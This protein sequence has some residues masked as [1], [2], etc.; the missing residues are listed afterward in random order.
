METHSNIIKF[1]VENLGQEDWFLEIEAVDDLMLET[2]LPQWVKACNEDLD[3]TPTTPEKALAYILLTDKF[4]RRM[5]K[6]KL[7]SFQSD[8]LA[9]KVA[10]KTINTN[11]D[12]RIPEPQ[13]KFFYFP[14]MHSECLSDQERGVRLMLTRMSETSEVQIKHA[15]AH[16][17]IIRSFG[18]FPFKNNVLSRTSRI[19]EHF[20]LKFDDHS[21]T[22]NEI[23]TNFF[24]WL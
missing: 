23:Q 9:K 24:L 19:P 3:F 16:R 7:K 1:W 15:K 18:R 12:L 22:F 14:L 10:K 2:F 4:P 20:N 21:K 8:R 17:Q 13:R 5:F 6:E 11:F